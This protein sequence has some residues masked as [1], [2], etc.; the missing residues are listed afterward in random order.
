MIQHLSCRSPPRGLR[1]GCLLPPG[2]ARAPSKTHPLNCR[3]FQSLQTLG[4]QCHR[5]TKVRSLQPR[6]KRPLGT[7][8]ARPALPTVGYSRG[9]LWAAGVG[10]RAHTRGTGGRGRAEARSSPGGWV[11][12]PFLARVDLHR[13]NCPQSGRSC[14]EL[15]RRRRRRGVRCSCHCPGRPVPARPLAPQQ[16][17][18]AP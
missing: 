15:R 10:G 6:G 5:V 1:R 16:P 12:V 18:S 9:A 2:D 3:T 17:G 13:G 14:L 11:P 8:G 4:S 7:Y